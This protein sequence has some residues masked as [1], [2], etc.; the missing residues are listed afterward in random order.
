MKCVLAHSFMQRILIVRRPTPIHQNYPSPAQTSTRPTLMQRLIPALLAIAL[1]AAPIR[2]GAAAPPISAIEQANAAAKEHY[3]AG[4]YLEAARVLEALWRETGDLRALVNAGIAFEAAGAGHEPWAHF[5]LQ[6]Y[7]DLA[8]SITPTDQGDLLLRLDAAAQRT[9]PVEFMLE[10]ASVPTQA[11]PT[12]VEVRRDAATT[13]D[14][15]VLPWSSQAGAAPHLR[16]TPGTWHARLLGPDGL[17]AAI[18]FTID[19]LPADPAR[20]TP[21]QITFP[22][23]PQFTQ[24]TLSFA[25]QRA[26]AR[27]IDLRWTGGPTSP[28]PA[29]TIKEPQRTWSLIPGAWE[30]H[31]RARGYQPHTAQIALT[32][33]PTH[34]H[35]T[36]LRDPQAEAKL[37]LA[38]STGATGLILLVTGLSLGLPAHRELRDGLPRLDEI[39]APERPAEVNGLLRHTKR[40]AVGFALASSGLGAGIVATTI[41]VDARDRALWA[42]F[43]LGGLLALAGLGADATLYQQLSPDVSGDQLRLRHNQRIAAAS[44]IGAGVGMGSAALIALATRKILQKRAR[45]RRGHQPPQTTHQPSRRVP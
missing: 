39:S 44:L 8:T 29:L 45:A 35:F 37:P 14:P 42:E 6:R 7:L 21:R 22:Q 30:L 12:H 36:L 27:G 2:E 20:A 15:L 5:Y 1:A 17:I 10:P 24:L 23:P 18:T 25:P 11:A 9:A 40:S 32:A 31:L 34:L 19:P 3:E 4:R 26:L 28:P 41:A 16:L 43:G 33:A 38:V 13:L